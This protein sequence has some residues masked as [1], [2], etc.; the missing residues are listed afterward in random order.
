MFRAAHFLTTFVIT[1]LFAGNTLPDTQSEMIDVWGS[2]LYCQ[3]IYEEP[4][5]S[6]RIYRGDRESCNEAHR[7]M[8]MHALESWPEEEVRTVFEHA[9]H[10]SAVIR[11]NTRSVQEAVAA[12]R[13]LC[14]AYND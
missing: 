7:S 13:E 5:I 8:G 10:K 1:P 14:R 11:Y 4:E 3:T 9:Q 6:E 2:V 12:C